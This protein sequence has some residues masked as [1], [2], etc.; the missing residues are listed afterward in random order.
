MRGRRRFV[1]VRI[2]AASPV[3]QIVEVREADDPTLCRRRRGWGTRNFFL[4]STLCGRRSDENVGVNSGCGT[5]RRSGVG[6]G[7]VDVGDEGV[8]RWLDPVAVLGDL[9]IDAKGAKNCHAAGRGFVD[10]LDDTFAD[11]TKIGAAAFD[12]ASG[13]SVAVSGGARGELI[14]E[15]NG[16]FRAPID[17]VGLDGIAVGMVADGA[18]AGVALEGGIGLATGGDLGFGRGGVVGASAFFAAAGVLFLLFDLGAGDERGVVLERRQAGGDS[19]GV[20]S[21]IAAG[22]GFGESGVDDDLVRLI[23]GHD[24]CISFNWMYLW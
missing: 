20:E 16:G 14:I 18:F 10:V 4:G 1:C 23:L 11:A 21:L 22:K 19:V 24:L 7:D 5:P 6:A 3:G 9:R 2:E 15:R 12:E 8:L 17:E 13:G